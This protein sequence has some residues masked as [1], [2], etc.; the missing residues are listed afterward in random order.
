MK[1]EKKKVI[2]RKKMKTDT[3]TLKRTP[4]RKRKNKKEKEAEQLNKEEKQKKT[5]GKET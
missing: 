5:R 4:L 2:N 1:K 3:K